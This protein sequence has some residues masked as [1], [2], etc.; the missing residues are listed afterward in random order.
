MRWDFKYMQFP[1]TLDVQFCRL[2]KC[3]LMV[4]ASR[5]ALLEPNDHSPSTRGWAIDIESMSWAQF[6][7]HQVISWTPAA[8]FFSIPFVLWLLSICCVLMSIY[9]Y[10]GMDLLRH[11]TPRWECLSGPL[12]D[13]HVKLLFIWC[14][15]QGLVLSSLLKFTVTTTIVSADCTQKGLH[16]STERDNIYITCSA[17]Q[18]ISPLYPVDKI[19]QYAHFP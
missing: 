17:C 13:C 18:C 14:C 2:K 6:I 1:K 4:L 7:L 3:I 10:V 15:V 16:V 8:G 9:Y 19:I 5:H 12:W 11:E